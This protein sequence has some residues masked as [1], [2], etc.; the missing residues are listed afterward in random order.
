MMAT[1]SDPAFPALFQSNQNQSIFG[2]PQN[3]SNS[4]SSIEHAHKQKLMH[5]QLQQQQQ[6]HAL[7]NMHLQ[8]LENSSIHGTSTPGNSSPQSIQTSQFSAD[9]ESNNDH[10][11]PVNSTA[12]P[13]HIN[14]SFSGTSSLNT[15]LSGSDVAALNGQE[16]SQGDSLTIPTTRQLP[17]SPNREVSPVPALNLG[18]TVASK[19]T[20]DGCIPDGN[21]ILYDGNMNTIPMTS[22]NIMSFSQLPSDDLSAGSGSNGLGLTT[23]TENALTSNSNMSN[24]SSIWS[25]P[26]NIPNENQG[27]FNEQMLYQALQRQQLPSWE[28]HNMSAY[29]PGYNNSLP[30]S[31]LNGPQNSTQQQQLQLLQHQLAL[32][33]S[34]A[35]ANQGMYGL[36]RSTSFQPST[37]MWKLSLVYVEMVIIILFA[38]SISWRDER[39]FIFILEQWTYASFKQY[40]Q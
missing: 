34:Q 14:G 21:R 12:S 31:L 19:S 8:Q 15:S 23:I 26:A 7:A 4:L 16:M 24:I 29:N 22:N 38:C 5:L 27:S 2:L 25:E 3:G 18:V 11:D 40:V 1:M 33:R 39:P 32:K 9:S 35:M 37:C 17:K 30:A 20:F 36:Q 6:H 28:Q 10:V 13:I